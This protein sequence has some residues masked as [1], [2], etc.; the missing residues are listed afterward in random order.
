[1]NFDHLIHS[2]AK[3]KVSEQLQDNQ[4]SQKKRKIISTSIQELFLGE[5][6]LFN[7]VSTSHSRV[8]QVLRNADGSGGCH[9]FRGKAL[10]NT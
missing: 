6:A 3:L 7:N 8:I 4:R 1:M 9:I 2:Y 10:R 5:T